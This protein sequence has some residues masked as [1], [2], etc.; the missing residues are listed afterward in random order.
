ML[1]GDDHKLLVGST[2]HL[3][4]LS[5]HSLGDSHVQHGMDVTSAK[6]GST[7]KSSDDIDNVDINELLEGLYWDASDN[8]GLEDIQYLETDD[9][10][11]PIETNPNNFDPDFFSFFDAVENQFMGWSS[12]PFEM[13][14]SINDE[15]FFSQVVNEYWNHLSLLCDIFCNETCIKV[16]MFFW[17]RGLQTKETSFCQITVST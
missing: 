14:S 2:S 13:G 10:S 6:A 5:E 16:W 12:Q 9:L 15:A 1:D 8:P 4:Q 7:V 3:L 17:Y 11:L